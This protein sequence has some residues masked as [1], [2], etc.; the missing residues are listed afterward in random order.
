MKMPGGEGGG[1]GGGRGLGRLGGR[2]EG[3]GAAG[4][5]GLEHVTL[6]AVRSVGQS[7]PDAVY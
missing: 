2:G 7:T 4:G 6:Q 1:A 3:E 5:S